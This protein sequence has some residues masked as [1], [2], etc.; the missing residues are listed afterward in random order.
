[1]SEGRARHKGVKCRGGCVAACVMGLKDFALSYSDILE[2]N[3]F[4]SFDRVFDKGRI[5]GRFYVCELILILA[6]RTAKD[7]KFMAHEGKDPY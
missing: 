7:I 2:R 1:M 4:N 3:K 5:I 6:R